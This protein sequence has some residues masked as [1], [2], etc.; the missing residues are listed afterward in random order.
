MHRY[1]A[2]YKCVS[3]PE[4]FYSEPRQSLDYPMQVAYHSKNWLLSTTILVSSSKQEQRLIAAAKQNN[5]A[6]NVKVS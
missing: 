6:T 2:L 5:V 3:T 4:E 1:I